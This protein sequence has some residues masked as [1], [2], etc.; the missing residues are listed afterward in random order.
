MAHLPDPPAGRLPVTLHY[1]LAVIGQGG[2]TRRP[3]ISASGEA[4]DMASWG[5]AR[6][7][8]DENGFPVDSGRAVLEP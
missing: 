6:G 4:L 2:G 1:D 5:H 7:A 8:R 3:P